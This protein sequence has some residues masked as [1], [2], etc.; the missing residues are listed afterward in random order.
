MASAAPAAESAIVAEAT[1]FHACPCKRKKREAEAAKLGPMIEHAANLTPHDMVYVDV[2]GKDYRIPKKS[3]DVPC[4][5]LD[6]TPPEMTSAIVD[7]RTFLV[8]RGLP[9]F[10]GMEPKEL[11]DTAI[12]V[13]LIAARHIVQFQRFPHAVF[14]PDTDRFAVRNAEGMIIGTSCMILAKECERPGCCSC[15]VAGCCS[16]E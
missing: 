9:Q 12:V 14:V 16:D 8:R 2:D 3:G 10:S 7:G 13:S 6:E 4:R 1:R 5:L 15:D 11:P